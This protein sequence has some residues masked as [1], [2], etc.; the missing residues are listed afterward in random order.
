MQM[1]F[2]WFGEKD[3]KITL[4]QI[5]QIPNVKGVVGALYDVP[6]GEVWPEDKIKH[7]KDVVEKAG[8]TLEVIESV[9][10]HDDIKIGLPSRDQYIEN[11]IQTIKKL[12]KYGIKVICY[13]FMPIFDWT[14]TDLAF[15]LEDGSIVLSYDQAIVDKIDPTNMVES[16]TSNS[17]GFV[18]PGWEPERLKEIK[19]LFEKYKDVDENK[20]TA[21]LKYFLEAIIP[22]CEE[23]DIKMAIHPD[24]PPKGIFGLPRIVKNFDDLKRIVEMVDSPSNCLTLCTG[25]LG[26]NPENNVPQLIRYFGERDRIAFAHCRNIK[27]TS[28]VNFHE[29]AHLSELGS[30]DMYEIMKAF[31]DVGFDGYMRPDHGRMIWGEVGRPGYGLYDRALGIAYLNGLWEALEKQVS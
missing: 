24:D 13:N 19:R 29:S 22:T 7:M 3:D 11:Y 31:H 26:E 28:D 5:K 2:R 14:R 30:L 27:F 17:N 9:N 1:I 6:V 25:S 20:L 10:I 15:E 4:Q 18:M 8:L 23:Y 21:N 12:S 16:L